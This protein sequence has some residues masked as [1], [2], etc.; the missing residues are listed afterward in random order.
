MVLYNELFFAMIGQFTIVGGDQTPT[1][2]R[3]ETG[4]T[5]VRRSLRTMAKVMSVIPRFFLMVSIHL[6]SCCPDSHLLCT[7]KYYTI[8]TNVHL[9]TEDVGAHV[10]NYNSFLS[11]GLGFQDAGE[12]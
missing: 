8:L 10:G 11:A 7:C 4:G 3:N 2:W 1:A 6:P 12:T 5:S 9:A